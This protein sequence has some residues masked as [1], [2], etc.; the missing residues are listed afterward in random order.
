M[1]SGHHYFGNLLSGYRLE[2]NG[3]QQTSQG[4]LLFRVVLAWLGK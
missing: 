3:L 2:I 1:G 4:A